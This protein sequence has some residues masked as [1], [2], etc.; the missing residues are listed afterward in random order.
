[1]Q[2]TKLESGPAKK[3][4]DFHEQAVCISELANWQGVTN[5]WTEVDWTVLDSQKRQK[6]VNKPLEAKL[7]IH[8]MTSS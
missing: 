6:K 8:I 4:Q 3:C 5:H 1:M 2:K 7:S